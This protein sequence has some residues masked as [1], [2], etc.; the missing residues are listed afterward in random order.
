M[1]C[2]AIFPAGIDGGA[3]CRNWRP[4]D[5]EFGV[6]SAVLVADEQDR[7][8]VMPGAT[9]EVD[10]GVAQWA[11]T[12]A[13]QPGGGTDTLPSS[14]CLVL[15]LK[16]TMRLR[17][18]MAAELTGSGLLNPEHR[19]V[20]DTCASLMAISI[21]RIHYIDVAQRTTVQMESNGYATR[22]SL[23]FHMICARL[24]RRWSAWPIYAGR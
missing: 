22:C 4:L 16:A 8:N 17:G 24:W 11:S 15:P 23:R 20:L 7:L 21:E 6:K 13:R 19:R 3:S 10:M 1:K 18:V 5:V 14:K 12:A 2:H 9:T